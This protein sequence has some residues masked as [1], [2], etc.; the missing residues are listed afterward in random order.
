MAID[1]GIP[2]QIINRRAMETHVAAEY[3]NDIDTIM[4]TI[5]EPPRY[6]LIRRGEPLTIFEDAAGPRLLYTDWRASY[7]CLDSRETRVVTS[8]WYVFQESV[9]FFRHKG[10][11]EGVDRTGTE[12]VI[13]YAVFVPVREPGRIVGEFVWG[14]RS[15]PDSIRAAVDGVGMPAVPVEGSI[16]ALEVHDRIVDV[17]RKGTVDELADIFAADARLAAR[18]LDDPQARFH[19]ASGGA[20]IVGYYRRLLG[21]QPPQ[22]LEVV[23]LVANDWY[24]FAEHRLRPASGVTISSASILAFDDAGALVAQIGWSPDV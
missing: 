11:F 20:E 16:A 19:Q 3:T 9:T 5:S 8:D 24:V 21:G 7:S 13:P 10:E 15:V 1:T 2:R 17:L 4:S 6:A 14:R 22:E 12:Y 23:Q 18:D